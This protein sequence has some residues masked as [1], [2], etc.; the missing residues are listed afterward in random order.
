M[1][2]FRKNHILAILMAFFAASFL[3]GCVELR[4]L[5]LYDTEAPAAKFTAPANIS[6]A[7]EPVIFD[8]DASNMWGL[9]KDSCQLVKITNL[10]EP[11][12]SPVIDAEW[13]RSKCKWSGFGIG[14]EDWVGKDLSEIMN[15]AAINI[16]IRARDEP[17]FELPMVLTLEDYSS[18]QSY[19]YTNSKYFQRTSLDKDWQTISIPLSTF[20]DVGK[21]IDLT[22]IKQLMFELQ[23]GG[24]VYIKSVKLGPYTPVEMEKWE[25]QQPVLPDPMAFPKVLFDDAFVDNTG[26]G[27]I[28]DACQD[29]H[30]TDEAASEGKK[31]VYVKWDANVP[32][33]SRIIFGANWNK[34][35]PADLSPVRN[36]TLISFDIQTLSGGGDKLPVSVGFLCY[37]A[38][39]QSLTL[40]GKYVAGGTYDAEWRQVRIPLSDLPKDADLSRIK[41][42]GIG[43]WEGKGE[44][45]ID[46]IRLELTEQ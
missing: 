9:E 32:D 24:A 34:W 36:R 41:S 17:M 38:P 46:N 1:I 45:R 19:S 26:W 42:L 25:V 12:G 4:Q 27:L 40:E 20:D 35:R 8:G 44:L 2:I 3:N 22:N 11:D 6:S 39:V 18:V 30:I 29:I 31:S 14:W 21:G 16:E 23:Q 5:S 13:N 28:K 10:P 43:F 7:V 37:D 15:T 33:C